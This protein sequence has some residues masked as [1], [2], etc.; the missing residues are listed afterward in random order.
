MKT[1]LLGAGAS[2]ATLGSKIAPISEG[3]GKTLNDNVPRW[4][5]QYPFLRSGVIYLQRQQNNKVEEDTW[6]L[7]AVWNGIDENYKLESIIAN[8]DFEWPS[9]PTGKRLYHQYQRPS[10]RCF[11]ILAGWELRRALAKLYGTSLQEELSKQAIHDK[12]LAKRLRELEEGDIVASTNYDLLAE[13][14]IQQKWPSASNCRTEQ[15]YRSRTT[16]QGPLILKLHGSLDW[17]FR[18]HWITKRSQIDR[19]ADNTAITDDDIDLDE[20]F[21]ETRPLVIAPVRYKDEIVFPSAQPP[22]LVEVLKFQWERLIDAVSKADELQVLGYGFP[23]DDSYGN[24]LI[25]EAVRRRPTAPRLRV[26]LYLR[27]DK[28]PKVKKRLERD[29]FRADKAQVECCGAIP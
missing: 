7:D 3:F 12:W 26:L 18:S 16:T 21:L 24:R 22:E 6:P 5:D 9:I 1:L 11:W 29:I 14:I 19:T 25:Q 23:P 10:W 15:E 4:K 13:S 17:L 28:C 27:D 8:N 20:T 2:F